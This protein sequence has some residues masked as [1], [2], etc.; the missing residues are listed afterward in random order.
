MSTNRKNSKL[1]DSN[2]IAIDELSNGGIFGESAES[3]LQ[4]YESLNE[5]AEGF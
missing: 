5:L 1:V 4:Q 3:L 2:N